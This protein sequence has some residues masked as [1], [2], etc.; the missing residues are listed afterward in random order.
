[1]VWLDD[2]NKMHGRMLSKA[3]VL[4]PKDASTSEILKSHGIETI[5]MAIPSVSAA[6]MKQLLESLRTFDCRV[7][8]LPSIDDIMANRVTA[9]DARTLPLEELTGRQPVAPDMALMQKNITG[10]VVMVTGVGGSVGSELCR[11][12]L[13][14]QPSAL[15]LFDVFEAALY[16]IEHNLKQLSANEQTP[17][18]HC[19]L[20]NVVFKSELSHTITTYRV[21]TLFHGKRPTDTPYQS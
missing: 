21:Q 4:D 2:D 8:T 15:V 19:V 16:E 12:I 18:V 13:P 10:K 20:G 5:L 9:R 7:K 1:M 6:H 14:L 11:Q 17:P 3:K